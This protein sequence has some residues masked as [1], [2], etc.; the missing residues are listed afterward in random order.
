M[1]TVSGLNDKHRAVARTIV[2]R[3]ADLMLAHKASVHYSQGP[4]RWDG[5]NRRLLISKGQF[6]SYSDC[7]SS[8]TWLLWNGLHVLFGVRDTVN[9]A[10]W[11]YGYTGTILQH[12]KVVRHESNIKVG[13][14]AVYGHGFPGEHVAVC[15]GGGYVFSHGSEAGPFKTTLHYRP[16]LIA[17]RRFI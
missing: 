4:R 9:G 2:A 16:D 15:L 12:G 11:R 7:S 14:L 1:S 6:P 3:G 10:D 8:S 13:D 17:V 5:I